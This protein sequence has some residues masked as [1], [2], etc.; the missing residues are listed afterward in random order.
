MIRCWQRGL[1]HME[2]PPQTFSWVCVFLV[3]NEG[4]FQS[5]NRFND[6]EFPSN[7]AATVWERPLPPPHITETRFSQFGLEELD[8]ASQDPDFNPVQHVW[9]EL[10]PRPQVRSY[11]P[12]CSWG[13][14]G[15]KPCSRV[16]NSCGE[17]FVR[18]TEAVT[19]Y[20]CLY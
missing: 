14:T 11:Y 18:R 19:D 4:T 10:D 13:C 5:Q 16:P 9:D 17:R 12:A 20:T 6:R 7:S 15:A 1:V 8:C 3:E 2:V